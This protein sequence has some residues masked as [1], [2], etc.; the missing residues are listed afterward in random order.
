MAMD[1]DVKPIR[2]AEQD[3]GRL[4][5]RIARCMLPGI[6]ENGLDAQRL[7]FDIV[8]T[9]RRVNR[10]NV[11]TEVVYR[12]RGSGR[13]LEDRK[14]YKNHR[15]S[16]DGIE[17]TNLDLLEG[18]SVDVESVFADKYDERRLDDFYFANR[19]LIP[20][21]IGEGT[22]RTFNFAQRRHNWTGKQRKGGEVGKDARSFV[23]PARVAGNLY[24]SEAPSHHVVLG[25]LHDVIEEATDYRQK[26]WKNT[27]DEGKRAEYIRDIRNPPEYEGVRGIFTFG[28][29]QVVVGEDDL[30]K[31]LVDSSD[32][33]LKIYQLRL[34]TKERKQAY[35]DYITAMV[36]GCLREEN[37]E[38]V[39][40]VVNDPGERELYIAAPMI[41]KAADAIDNTNWLY[42]LELKDRVKRLERNIDVLR[43]IDTF[44]DH[45]RPQLLVEL[46]AELIVRSF[47]EIQEMEEH[48]QRMGAEEYAMGHVI[49]EGV[50]RFREAY[51][52]Y[53]APMI[54]D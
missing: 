40:N 8:R 24:I 5:E 37:R 38:L 48:Y 30:E 6:L 39:G 11:A 42:E 3:I 9:G 29:R 15:I 22:I 34:L 45:Y 26:L 36:E 10:R 31:E 25:L 49:F 18:D 19:V 20:W 2:G 28:R 43:G 21:A 16:T 50:T 13:T 41:V 14:Y 52:M 32:A 35:S 27:G 23:H 44:L 46:R 4:E 47:G 7:V 54:K 1:D 51:G 17:V 53:E 12:L 33:E